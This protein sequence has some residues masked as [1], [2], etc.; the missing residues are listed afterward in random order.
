MHRH[1]HALPKLTLTSQY[2]PHAWAMGGMHVLC[3]GVLHG[4]WP[5]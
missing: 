3:Y 1:L 4:L 2:T 5:E